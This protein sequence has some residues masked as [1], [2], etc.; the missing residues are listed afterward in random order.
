MSKS[1]SEAFED[2]NSK[3]QF[4]IVEVAKGRT[5]KRVFNKDNSFV[6]SNLSKYELREASKGFTDLPF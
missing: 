4:R 3:K 2:N 1:F 6:D 5:V